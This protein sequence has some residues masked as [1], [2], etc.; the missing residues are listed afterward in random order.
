MD[1]PL[2]RHILCEIR[3]SISYHLTLLFRFNKN[4]IEKKEVNQLKSVLCSVQENK[5]G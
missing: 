1:E 4:Q 2:L 3:I 5:Y